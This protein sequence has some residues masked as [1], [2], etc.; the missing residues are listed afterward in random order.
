MLPCRD[1]PG[2]SQWEFDRE[3]DDLCADFGLMHGLAL[4]P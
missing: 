3:M 1:L 4:F 2:S